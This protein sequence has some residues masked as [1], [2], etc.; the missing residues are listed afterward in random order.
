MKVKYHEDNQC[1]Y[2][3]KFENGD[4]NSRDGWFG[5]DDDFN[6][7]CDGCKIKLHYSSLGKKSAQKRKDKTNYSEL[8]KKR[9]EKV[10]PN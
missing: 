1:A 4:I 5:I 9:W 2:C 7:V 6:K 8:A 10:K 3:G